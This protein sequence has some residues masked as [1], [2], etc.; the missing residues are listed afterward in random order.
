MRSCDGQSYTLQA[1]EYINSDGSAKLV[2]Y[3]ANGWENISRWTA[4]Q[5]YSEQEFGRKKH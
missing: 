2:L 3:A 4:K 1:Y 5:Q